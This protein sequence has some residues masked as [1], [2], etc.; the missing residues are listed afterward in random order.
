MFAKAQISLLDKKNI[1]KKVQNKLFIFAGFTIFTSALPAWPHHSHGN[2][3][4][5]EWAFLEGTVSELR[6]INPHSWFYIEVIGADDQPAI[7]ALEANSLNR[8]RSDGW[9]QDTLTVGDKIFVQCHPLKDGSNG[10]LLGYIT[11]EDGVELS[12]RQLQN[13]LE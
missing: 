7:W 13:V 10:C 3:L 9:T 6:W 1:M 5:S 8:L 2:Y 4:T 11:T 12:G